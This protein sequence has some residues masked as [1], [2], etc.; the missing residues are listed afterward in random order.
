M[1]GN[2]FAIFLSGYG[3]GAI[4]IL[5]AYEKGLV[6]PQLSLV[7]STM[8]GSE[9][10]NL[11]KRL[12]VQTCVV[13][14]SACSSRE[15]FENEIL[16]VLVEN[17]I[18]YVFLAGFKYLLSKTFVES[19]ARP[20][21]NIHPSLLPAFKG[22][23]NAIQQAIEFGVKVTGVTLHKI[24]HNMDEGEIIIQRVVLIEPTDNFESLDQKVLKVGNQASLDLINTYFLD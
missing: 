16:E 3:R 6:L 22:H 23:K 5:Q 15:C 24:D 18:D 4:S 9:A 12:G 21:V 1:I 7:L 2:R 14:M 11:A 13:E 20:I 17:S 8:Q 19:Y 10:V